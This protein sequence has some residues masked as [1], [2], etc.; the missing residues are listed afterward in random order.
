LSFAP[1]IHLSDGEYE[2]VLRE[3]DPKE[4]KCSPKK[5]ATWETK[6]PGD[7]DDQVTIL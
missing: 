1:R 4:L 2:V 6:P 3:K 5:N 7:S